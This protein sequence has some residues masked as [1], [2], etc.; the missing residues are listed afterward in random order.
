MYSATRIFWVQLDYGRIIFTTNKRKCYI[1]LQE[2]KTLKRQIFPRL[3]KAVDG[4]IVYEIAL[5]LRATRGNVPFSA[6]SVDV[7]ACYYRGN[8]SAVIT[9][10]AAG[11]WKFTEQRYFLTKIEGSESG[12]VR[13]LDSHS[14]THTLTTRTHTHPYE[15]TYANPTAMSTFEGLSTGR[16]GDSRS[17]HWR[18]VVDG[19]VA[20]HLTRNA[21]KSQNKYVF[22]RWGI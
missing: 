15:Y 21:G 10:D 22:L 17:H 16:S 8:V 3:N 9:P 14:T 18:L 19:N 4:A 13:F 5:G 20:Y 6:G 2:F 7:T 1:V 11:S 12:K